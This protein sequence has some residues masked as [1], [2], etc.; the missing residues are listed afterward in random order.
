MIRYKYL[1]F[2]GHAVRQMFSRQISETDVWNVL[3]TGEMII[4]YPDDKPLPSKLI[5]GFSEG[6][7]IHVVFAY[8]ATNETGYIVTAYIPDKNLWSNDF[9]TRSKT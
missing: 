9:K 3:N 7:P 6:R 4:D 2:T 1:N 5:L 8:D